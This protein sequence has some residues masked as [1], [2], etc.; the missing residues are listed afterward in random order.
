MAWDRRRLLLG[1]AAFGIGMTPWRGA[2]AELNCSQIPGGRACDALIRTSRFANVRAV[3]QT[4]V[5]CWAA[6]L[7]MIFRWHGHPISQQSIV[8]QTFGAPVVTTANPLVLINA[9]NR[10]YRDD[11]GRPFQVSA[12]VWGPDYGLAQIDNRTLVD[13]LS[14]E[15][16]LVVCNMSHMMALVGINFV[17]GSMGLQVRQ[18]WVADPMLLGQVSPDLAA[19]FRYLLPAEIIPATQGGQLRFVADVSVS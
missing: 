11:A 9:V 12:R 18:A 4:L 16:P 8:S 13:S 15:R 10:A 3:Q 6:T 19:G 1:L 7:E 5:W 17:Q 2:Q 14:R